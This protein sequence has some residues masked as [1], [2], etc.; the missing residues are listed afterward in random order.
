MYKE[1]TW[2]GSILWAI[3]LVVF[4]RYISLSI[5]F[6]GDGHNNH[7]NNFFSFVVCNDLEYD[8]AA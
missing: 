2:F 4:G 5:R 8:L 6:M 1:T 3:L 7:G